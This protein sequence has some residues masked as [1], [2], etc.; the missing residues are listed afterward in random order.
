MLNFE[1]LG[2]VKILR[3]AQAI[4]QILAK[5]VA[6]LCPESSKICLKSLKT[7]ISIN[8]SRFWQSCQNLTKIDENLLENI[9]LSQKHAKEEFCGL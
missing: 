4:S 8:L 2:E 7:S 9:R 5:N 3:T 1:Q 6:K